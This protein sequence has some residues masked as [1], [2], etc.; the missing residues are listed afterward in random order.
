MRDAFTWSFPIG[1]LFGIT[2]R[3]H[4]F[5]PILFLGLVWR[6]SD[7]T[8]GFYPGAW[9]D[10][11]MLLG[12]M[13]VSVLLHELGHCFAARRVE[14]DADEVLL[15]PLGGLARCD[16]PH[17]PLANFITALGGPL[18]NL[19][20]CVLAALA[21][22]FLLEPSYRP[23]WN[24]LAPPWRIAADGRIGLELWNGVADTTR[25]EAL[26]AI[27]LARFFW[28]NWALLLLNI[29]LIG[30][31]F[32]GGLMLQCAL[33]P[34]LGYRQALL[35]AIF[36]GF[37]IMII[38]LG[39][40]IAVNEVVWL[41][42]AWYCYYSCKQEWIMLETGGD[43]SVF[44]YDF[45]QGYT[46]LEREE[47]TPQTPPRRKKQNFLQRW[48]HRRSARKMQQAQQQQA[49]DDRRMDELLEKIQRYGKASLTDEEQRFLKRV[50]DRYRNKPS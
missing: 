18:V 4:F 34:Y 49:Q 35:Y 7:T 17:T 25:P 42:L 26:G 44:G 38:L 32:D 11:A 15:W 3:V 40:S 1:Y 29:C 37:G 28:V 8:K 33:W 24:P 14:G 23:P 6:A 31:P 5:V 13:F 20:L 22:A 50:S 39:V 2:V 21:L 30:L 10:M 41:L 36:A 45:S 19:I 9:L 16:V 27:V 48:L 43:D 46:S 47:E 12:L